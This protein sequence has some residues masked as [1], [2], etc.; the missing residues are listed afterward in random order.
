MRPT[1]RCLVVFS[2]ALVAAAGALAQSPE[3]RA[4]HMRVMQLYATGHNEEAAIVAREALD[5]GIGEFG[6]VHPSTAALMVNLAD[7]HAVLEEWPEAET[8]FRRAAAVRTETLGATHP[9]TGAAHA[10]LGDALARQERFGEAETSYWNALHALGVEVA[11]NVHVVDEI[12][13]RAGLYRARALYYRAHQ[14]AA[15]DRLDEAELIYQSVIAVFEANATVD[16]SEVVA[17]LGARAAL[18]RKLGRDSEALELEQ[19]AQAVNEGRAS[20]P[21]GLFTVC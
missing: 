21:A 1:I 4:K 12:S 3:L 8:L 7:L 2:V 6:E 11:R 9:D 17:A 14:Y 5:L 18:L 20:C 13:L 10:G 16:R 15:A 19:Y